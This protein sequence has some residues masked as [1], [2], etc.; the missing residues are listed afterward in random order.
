MWNI[1]ECARTCYDVRVRS[2]G[3]DNEEAPQALPTPAGPAKPR[4]FPQMATGII[5]PH[6]RQRAELMAPSIPML[7]RGRSK[8]TGQS[9][10][11]VPGSKAGTV[12]YSSSLGCTCP[13]FRAR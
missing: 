11:L 3:P 5:T 2:N 10:Y 12:Y 1:Q 9:F 6:I 7:S 4:R 8:V 13:G